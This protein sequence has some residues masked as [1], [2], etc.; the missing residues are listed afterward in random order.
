M[1]SFLKFKLFSESFA[2]FSVKTS[3]TKVQKHKIEESEP[4]HL[5]GKTLQPISAEI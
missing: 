1:N 2:K 5:N 4:E 3:E